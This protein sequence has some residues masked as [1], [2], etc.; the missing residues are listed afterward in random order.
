MIDPMFEVGISKVIQKIHSPELDFKYH[1][2]VSN[3]IYLLRMD[4]DETNP[5]DRYQP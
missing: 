4:V 1:E 3:R 2:G 5:G